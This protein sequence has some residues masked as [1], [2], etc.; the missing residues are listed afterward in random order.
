MNLTHVANFDLLLRELNSN[1]PWRLDSNPFEFERHRQML[2]LAL[3]EGIVT[4][5]LEVG[6]ASGAFTEK[7]APHCRRLTVIDVVPEAIA[8]T[9]ARLMESANIT[10]IVSDIQRFSAPDKF[11]LIVVAEVLYYL[12]SIAEVRATV[13]SLARM[14]APNG[15]LVF[16]SA[17]DAN[18]RRWGHIA[19]AE[20]VLEMLR[21]ELTE[22]K[23]VQCIGRSSNEDCMLARF[24]SPMDFTNQPNF[25]R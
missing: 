9:R 7:L 1:D 23:R 5:A 22:V 8:R 2:R 14:L 18:C 21:E 11:D 25:L 4:N 24:R 6:C 12:G 15:Q 10:W 13:Q 17:V 3:A 19:G 16:G 20:T